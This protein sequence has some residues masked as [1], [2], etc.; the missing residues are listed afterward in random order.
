[1]SLTL[2]IVLPKQGASGFIVDAKPSST[3]QPDQSLKP[4]EP[5]PGTI[6]KRSQANYTSPE[7]LAIEGRSA[8]GMLIGAVLNM[9]PDLFNTAIAGGFCA[10]ATASAAAAAAVF[11]VGG[12]GWGRRSF[13]SARCA[14]KAV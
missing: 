11:D 1:V 5:T 13:K 7:G 9:R 3:I 2:P 8:G 12:G 4:F 14:S 6:P 10:A